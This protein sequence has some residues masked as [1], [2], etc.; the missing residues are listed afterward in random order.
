M[1]KYTIKVIYETGDTS[2]SSIIEENIDLQWETIE[3]AR[4]ALQV[5]KEHWEYTIRRDKCRTR[6]EVTGLDSEMH[7]KTWYSP[8]GGEYLFRVDVDGTM[9]SCHAPWVGYFEVLNS[10]EVVPVVEEVEN[11]DKINFDALRWNIK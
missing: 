5:L 7:T 3:G 4:N 10:A 6:D 8:S 1:S 11:P 2:S 9:C